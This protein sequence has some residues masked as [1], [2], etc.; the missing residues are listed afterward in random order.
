MILFYAFDRE[1]LFDDGYLIKD[2][3]FRRNMKPIGFGSG[4]KI[5]FM[6]NGKIVVL[7]ET[8][9]G[10]DNPV[11]KAMKEIGRKEYDYLMDNDQY[12]QCL[13]F[14]QTFNTVSK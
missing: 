14:S 9:S 6:A 8:G 3:V 10:V 4:N 13:I 1:S 12:V 11:G 5:C 2:S 7:T